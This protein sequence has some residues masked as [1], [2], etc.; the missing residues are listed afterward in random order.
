MNP[1]KSYEEVEKM[2]DAYCKRALKNKLKDYKRNEAR[3]RKHEI[4][5][6]VMSEGE[7]AIAEE[8]MFIEILMFKGEECVIK[9][10]S[11]KEALGALPEEKFNIIMF[12]Y[13]FGM[14]DK[15]ISTE[16][17]QKRTTVRNK[18][19]SALYILR[20]TLGGEK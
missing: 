20:E 14:T 1:I 2:F 18:R 7:I 12:Y 10:S 13:F 9:S 3:R 16:L 19:Y 11:L 5:I 15:E 6:D 17:N 8:E 4:S